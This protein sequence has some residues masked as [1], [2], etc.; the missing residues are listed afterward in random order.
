M[1]VCSVC[2]NRDLRYFYVGTRGEYCRKCVMYISSVEAESGKRDWDCGDEQYLLDYPLTK[3]QQLASDQIREKVVWNDVLVDA[4]CGAGKTELVLG[5]IED[6][7]LAR[8]K[9]GWAIPRRQVVLELK[10]RLAAFF[11]S[12]DVVAVCQGYTDKTDG[13]LILC[14]THQ[15]YR[16]KDWF[17]LLILDEPDAFP[18]KGN[19]M[20]AN[21]ARNACRGKMIYLTATPDKRLIEEV[22]MG[23]LAWVQLYAR[24]H[25][26]PVIVPKVKLMPNI[27]C[28]LYLLYRIRDRRWLIFVPTRKIAKT[29]AMFL[30]VDYLTS[31][32][33]QKEKIIDR[34]RNWEKRI[35]ISTT[36]LERGVT[37]ENIDVIVLFADHPVFDTASLIQISGRVG[38]SFQF[39]KGECIF[40][41][42]SK[43]LAV[44]EC[45]R[46]V[47][48]A[49]Q[50]VFGV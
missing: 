13:D 48:E 39:P 49:N 42:R 45:L 11:P 20:L 40:L 19:D 38:R 44:G 34:F 8:K 29:L 33:E 27:I 36:I 9:V 23:R 50:S 14:T 26:H 7:L 3:H 1:N 2:G 18:Y 21:F 32:S 25:G 12:L 46:K 47:Q 16:Y 6:A 35:L 17:D 43:T 41:S 22:E 30:Q 4:V 28:Q 37:F 5:A 10:V 31:Q 24:P 15:L